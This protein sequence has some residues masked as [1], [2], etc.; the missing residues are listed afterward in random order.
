MAHHTPS[1]VRE[2]NGEVVEPRPEEGTGVKY[3]R[4]KTSR[5]EKPPRPPDNGK[6]KARMSA[7]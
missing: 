1:R 5:A 2:F 4:H 6:G 3:S 7:E